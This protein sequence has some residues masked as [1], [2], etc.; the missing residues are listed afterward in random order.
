MGIIGE[1]MT[2]H[3]RH[4]DDVFDR[5]EDRASAADWPGVEHEGGAFLNAMERHIDIEEDL[6]FPAFEKATGM[7]RGPT[8]VMRSEHEELR[9]L[10][11]QMRTAIESK[12]CAQYQA[13][14]Q[15]LLDLLRL[16]NSKEE[17]ML[18]PML[19]QVLHAEASTLLTRLEAATA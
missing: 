15:A 16:H 13:V 12:D 19:D 9:K 6:L 10:F 3:H 14:A 18:Y 11:A 4:C 2:R 5:A 17:G 1:H 7:T 8:Q